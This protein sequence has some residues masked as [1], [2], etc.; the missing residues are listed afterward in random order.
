[1]MELYVH[2]EQDIKVV[3]INTKEVVSIFNTNEELMKFILK[4]KICKHIYIHE[5]STNGDFLT[6]YLLNNGYVNIPII[7]KKTKLNTKEFQKLTSD[8]D[9][10]Y[11]YRIRKNT[12]MQVT[13]YNSSNI[14]DKNIETLR[15]NIFKDEVPSYLVLPILIKSMLDEGHNKMTIGSNA[16]REFLNLK[17]NGNYFKFKDFFPDIECEAYTYLRNAY[18]GDW[19]F[20][21]DKY[22]DIEIKDLVG[23]SLEASSLFQYIMKYSLL[24]YGEPKYFKD[25]YEEDKS[26][27][28]YIQQVEI[29]DFILKEG[30]FPIIKEINKPEYLASGYKVVITV[31]NE[32]LD[33]ILESYDIRRINYIDGYKFRPCKGL[34]DIYIDKYMERKNNAINNVEKEIAILFLNNLHGKFRTNHIRKGSK[35]TIN[36]DGIEEREIIEDVECIGSEYYL[37]MGLFIYSYA[38]CTI[39]RGAI[40]NADRFIY[41]NA[42]SLYLEGVLEDVKGLNIQDEDLGAWALKNFTIMSS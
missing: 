40:A 42:N 27:P 24:P 6:H 13:I 32:E 35:T 8:R 23:L 21:N 33:L 30:Y 29:C 9:E 11:S 10:V 28:L 18:D 26:R 2:F 19:I 5:L 22:K 7:N 41:A 1:M 37:P 20:L 12:N 25:K 15:S 31:T 38:R 14:F 36:S 16:F 4:G 39:I 34:F 17:Y 3:D